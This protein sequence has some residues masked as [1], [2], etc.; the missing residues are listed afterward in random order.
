MDSPIPVPVA[1]LQNDNLSV[2]MRS[3]E[4]T[5]LS[6]TGGVP[7]FLVLSHFWSFWLLT[8]GWML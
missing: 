7:V 5:L 8:G 2:R 3:R 1:D 6:R 4:S